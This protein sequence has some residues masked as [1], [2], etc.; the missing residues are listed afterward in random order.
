[1][2]SSYKGVRQLDKEDRLLELCRGKRVL[3]LGCTDWPVTEEKAQDGNLLHIKLAT[4][5]GEL[6]GLDFSNEGIAALRQKCKLPLYYCDLTKDCSEVAHKLGIF[7]WILC[8][9]ILEHVDNFAAALTNLKLF[10]NKDSRLVITVPNSFAMSKVVHILMSNNEKQHPEHT[11]SF[12]I[13]NLQT[14]LGRH[15][16]KILSCDGFAYLSDGRLAKTYKRVI[17]RFLK[18]VNR[19]GL[20]DELFVIAAL[21]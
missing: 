8:C 19:S 21:E 18:I 3:H 16:L 5:T 12:S 11:C 10:M 13:V 20:A 15:G 4:V 9:D 17:H 2:I 7:D 6:V 14:L 1:M